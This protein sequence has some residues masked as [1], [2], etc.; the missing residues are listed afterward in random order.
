M[1]WQLHLLLETNMS[2]VLERMMKLA[3]IKKIIVL[4][5]VV[6]CF[7]WCFVGCSIAVVQRNCP[8]N[9]SNRLCKCEAHA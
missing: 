6:G 8:Q 1:L 5:Q 4:K 9:L 2:K 7:E 3:K